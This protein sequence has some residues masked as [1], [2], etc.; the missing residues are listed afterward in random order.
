ME[1]NIFLC[2]SCQ[3]FL[4]DQ[5]NA[6]S[7]KMSCTNQYGRNECSGFSLFSSFTSDS[8]SS[9]SSFPFLASSL[10]LLR[11]SNKV[12]ST[13]RSQLQRNIDKD[14]ECSILCQP[15]PKIF[16]KSIEIHPLYKNQK[17]AISRITLNLYQT[18]DIIIYWKYASSR[19]TFVSEN[20]NKHD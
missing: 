3:I 18:F 6:P 12:T 7:E 9:F 5:G 16:N 2:H 14:R 17:Y 11:L 19:K 20:S 13:Y 15:W 10:S 8:F 1:G 4:Y